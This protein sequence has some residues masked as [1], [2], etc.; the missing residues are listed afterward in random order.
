MN[1][2]KAIEFYRTARGLSTTELGNKIGLSQSTISKYENSARNPSD[3]TVESIAK[4]LDITVEELIKQAQTYIELSPENTYSLA[5]LLD[6]YNCMYDV[7]VPMSKTV[8]LAANIHAI[9]LAAKG[10]PRRRLGRLVSPVETILSNVLTEII[11]ENRDEITRRVLE[12]LR[13]TETSIE[14]I[15]R[16]LDE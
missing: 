4:A 9:D 2:G 16:N 11:E 12:E 14:E 6:K 15:L 10:L 5:Q 1:I 7:I 3:E 13:Y 8:L